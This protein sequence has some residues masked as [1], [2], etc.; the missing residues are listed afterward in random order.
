[1]I[2]ISLDTNAVLD[3]CYRSHPEHVFPTLWQLLQSA[4]MAG[5]CRFYMCSTAYAEIV[6]QISAF[7][8]DQTYFDTFTRILKVEVISRDD[9]GNQINAIRESLTQ[10]DFARS[11]DYAVRDNVDVDVMATALMFK[12]H[13]VTCE[14]ANLAFNW[15]SYTGKPRTKLKIPEV[16]DLMQVVC[17]N[18]IPVFEQL[19]VRI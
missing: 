4:V 15:K 1:M 3:F 17:S 10:Y 13:V 9:V 8:F 11:S 16:C 7:N 5:Q 12:G 18:W 6:S 2:K 14:Y 19:G